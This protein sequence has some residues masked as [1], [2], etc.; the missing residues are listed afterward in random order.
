[1][2]ISHAILHVLDFESGGTSYSQRE[3]DLADRQ[4][5]SYVQ[6]HLR[7]ARNSADNKHGAFA[8]ES[9]FVGE[10]AGYLDGGQNF[11]DFSTQIAEF[12]YDQL[13]LAEKAEPCDVL[14]ADFE[15]DP[16]HKAAP[17]S[18][19]ADGTDPADDD[20]FGDLDPAAAE[21]AAA[22]AAET[23]AAFEGRGKRCFAV[24]LLPRK[25]AFAHDV[26]AEGG[27]PVNGIVRHDATLP[28]PT[29]KVDSYAVIEVESRAVDFVDK[30]RTIAGDEI[31]VLPDRLLQCSTGASCREVLQQVTRIVEDVAREYGAN[32][33]VATAKA[34]AI[35]NEKAEE[36]EYLPPWDLGCE[37]F[38]DEPAMRERFEQTA[39]DEEL[40]E[41]LSVKRSVVNRAA[42]SHRIRTDTGIEVIFP[43]EYSTNPEFIE[44]ITE[45]DGSL[46]IELKNIGSI[47]NR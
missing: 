18:A 8:P 15:D 43:S 3:L 10:L 35:M 26:Y 33:A 41:R 11:V 38:E 12:L 32:A 30:P 47:E 13:R 44:F 39:R 17:A 6:R 7:R 25:L 40:P 23:D 20:P 24:L 5:K 21:V 42:K 28:N 16:E 29:Q 36:S 19:G 4:T 27:V 37:V 45:A 34:K 14:V 31:M 1:M 9:A 22:L 46:S 2:N